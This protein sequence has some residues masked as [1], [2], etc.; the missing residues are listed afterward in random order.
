[1][2]IA[3]RQQLPV[4]RTTI[5]PAPID[6]ASASDRAFLAMDN[7]DVPEQ[8]G[9][10][11]E[12]DGRL[13]LPRVRDRVGDRIRTVPRLRQRLVTVPF[14]CGGPVWVDD[15]G[16]DVT[17]HVR[18]V[19]CRAPGDEQ[20]LMDTALEV[21]MTPLRRSEPLW[22]VVLMTALQGDRSALVVVLHHV[23]ADGIGGLTVLAGLVDPGPEGHAVWTPRPRP[24][25][26][27]LLRDAVLS[28]A[29]AVTRVAESW[30]L[31]R[32]SM[33]AGGGL[34]PPQIAKC[35][36]MR[37]T[38]TRRRVTVVRAPYDAVRAAAHRHGATTNDAVLV[39][40]ACALRQVLERR[41]ES[42]DTLVVAVPVSGRRTEQTAGLG[43][44]VSPMLVAV[45][46][47]GA[48][49]QRLATVAAIVRAGKAGASGPPPI[50]VLGWLF[51]PLAAVGGYRWYMN[52]Q[53]RL[54]TLVS[55]VRGPVEPVSFDG[56]RIVSAVPLVVAESG[57]ATVS[58]EVLSYAG[59]LTV[60]AIVDPDHF[61]DQ[62]V[63]RACLAEAL[64]KTCSLGGPDGDG[65]TRSDA[66][67]T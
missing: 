2:G 39:A 33:R 15:A 38:G 19:V 67:G 50:A 5:R 44:L 57:N 65:V 56:R 64:R 21:V 45:P 62:E 20:A 3:T 30:R 28:K 16:F 58:F 54:H 36:L 8:F 41:G 37:Q 66:A 34:R 27:D 17:H 43:N 23:L 61:P 18:E 42:V 35:S 32:D 13:S 46:T 7:G 59:T 11:L 60:A 63:L 49:A 1:M 10:V 14:G 24:S 6:R 51:R 4:S 47:T 26:T 22:S 52:H 48:T 9:V 55:H 53:H 40:V 29:K 25:V 12:L 31:L